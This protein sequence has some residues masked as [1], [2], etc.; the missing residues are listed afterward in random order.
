MKPHT[1]WLKVGAAAGAANSERQP[2]LEVGMHPVV[3]E[4]PQRGEL[5]PRFG[6]T[7]VGLAGGGRMEDKPDAGILNDKQKRDTPSTPTAALFLYR[8]DAQQTIS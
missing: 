5:R 7:P 2:C 6:D 1:R 3:I 8:V 4:D